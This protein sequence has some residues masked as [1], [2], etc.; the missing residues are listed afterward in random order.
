MTIVATERA[1]PTERAIAAMLVE[2]TGSHFLDSGGAYGRAWQHTRAA[3][4]LDS[5]LPNSRWH[6]GPR[7]THDPSIDEIERVA[8]A[9][10]EGPMGSIDP[11]GMVIVDTFHWLVE[12]LEYVPALNRKFRRYIDK[13]WAHSEAGANDWPY[14]P[15]A[16]EKFVGVLIERGVT[17]QG[18]INSV[19]TYNGE[20]ALSRTLQYTAF[21]VDEDDFLPEGSYVALQIHGGADVRG[22]Y[23]DARLFRMI[24]DN[25]PWGL[26]DNDRTEIWCE[27][28][29]VLPEGVIAGQIGM[30]GEIAAPHDTQ[31]RWDNSYG[32]GHLRLTYSDDDWL[33]NWPSRG[34]DQVLIFLTEHDDEDTLK[35]QGAQIEYGYTSPEGRVVRPARYAIANIARKDENDVWRCPFDGSLLK[36]SG[37]YA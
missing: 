7:P 17:K 37:A 3:Y 2:N 31:H 22:G 15:S 8:L 12:R 29:Q 21:G 23:T 10:R 1:T 32:D 13:L 27:G 30:D 33:D 26:S 24:G 16:I 4:G 36:V 19:N 28:A 11:Y 25:V 18:D 20:D 9:M 5:G 35:E 34:E 14:E 6:G